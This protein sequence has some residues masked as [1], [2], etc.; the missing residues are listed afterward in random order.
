[1]LILPLF[2]FWTVL[3]VREVFRLSAARSFLVTIVSGIVMFI[4]VPVVLP[5]FSMLA[6]SPF[7]LIFLFLLLRG[8]FS[9]ITRGH[10]ARASF[11]Q[12]L[13]A[14]TLNPAD[15]SAHYNLGLIHQQRGE[16]EEARKR[17]ERAVEIDADELDAHYQLGRIAREQGR[18]PD[19]INHFNETVAR[20]FP[21]T[22][23][24]VR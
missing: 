19:A 21:T 15:A 24:T 6:F 20:G 1:M 18:L 7:W 17:F 5:L 11:K 23:A 10:R 14:A 2:A 22:G 9:D 12:N 8:Y 16:L 13:E 4:V 3:G